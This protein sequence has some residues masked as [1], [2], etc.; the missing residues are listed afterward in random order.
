MAVCGSTGAADASCRPLSRQNRTVM[1]GRRGGAGVGGIGNTPAAH[2]GMHASCALGFADLCA[3]L[4]VHTSRHSATPT[5]AGH[6]L[7]PHTL[8]QPKNTSMKAT[9]TSGMRGELPRPA[10][11]ISHLHGG[12]DPDRFRYRESRGSRCAVGGA[13]CSPAGMAVAWQARTRPGRTAARRRRPVAP[14]RASQPTSP[15]SSGWLGK[16]GTAADSKLPDVAQTT[17]GFRTHRTYI[18]GV[19]SSH[20]RNAAP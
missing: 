15:L 12:T 1:T 18:S 14:M 3:R 17:W 4:P 19:D 7:G 8:R 16:P 13:V 11:S 20:I 5:R 10:F 2:G 9:L 6:S